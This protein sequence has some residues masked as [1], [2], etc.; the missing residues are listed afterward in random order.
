MDIFFRNQNKTKKGQCESI[1]EASSS[2]HLL[3]YELFQY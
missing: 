2:I 3:E 1:S